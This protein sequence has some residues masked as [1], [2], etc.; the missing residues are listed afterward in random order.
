MLGRSVLLGVLLCL[1]NVSFAG[2]SGENLTKAQKLANG[3]KLDFYTCQLLTETA[4]LMGEMKGSMDKDAYSCVGK[5]KVKRKEEYKSVRE[6][7]KSSPDALTE[8]KDLY[9]YWVSSFDVLIPESGDTKRGY[10]D[11]VS[12]RSQGINDRSNRY[13][14]ELEM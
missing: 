5:Y 1:A 12:A 2:L 8:L 10:K 4:L 13:L 9:A 7:L 14:I 3:M 6:L 11:K